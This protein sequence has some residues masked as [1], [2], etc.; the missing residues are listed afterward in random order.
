[1]ISHHICFSLLF[2]LFWCH[3]HITKCYIVNSGSPAQPSLRPEP[4]N[5]MECA[6][7]AQ[8]R[9]SA[10]VGKFPND[11]LGNVYIPLLIRL[12]LYIGQT[13]IWLVVSTHPKNMSQLGSG[14]LFPI[15][16]KIKKVPNHQPDMVGT[17]NL[18]RFLI[19]GHWHD[20]AAWKI[21]YMAQY[22]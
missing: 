9:S 11:Q 19:Q 6:A 17:S 14:W 22:L 10:G 18:H 3:S 5:S 13:Y 2:N 7:A 20:V 12:K 4:W 16:G 8:Q 21:G 1:M 15:Y